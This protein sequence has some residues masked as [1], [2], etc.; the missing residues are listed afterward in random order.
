VRERVKLFT[1]HEVSSHLSEIDRPLD[2]DTIDRVLWALI[3]LNDKNDI[4]E[5]MFERTSESALQDAY[6]F[7]LGSSERRNLL[8][9]AEILLIM[10]K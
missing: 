3:E 6:Q 5:D 4:G 7:P 8:L 2:A 9:E 10:G 1:R